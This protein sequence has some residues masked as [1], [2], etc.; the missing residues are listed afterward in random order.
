MWINI[1]AVL[2]C[3]AGAWIGAM[4]GLRAA[5]KEIQE[6]IKNLK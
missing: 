3:L 2:G 1:A 5:K 6:K 4:L